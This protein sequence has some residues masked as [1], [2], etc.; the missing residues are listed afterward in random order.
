VFFAPQ[1]RQSLSLSSPLDL[2]FR[3]WQYTREGDARSG[4]GWPHPRMAW[5]GAGPR[6]MVMW[7]PCCS[8]RSPL[9]A[10]FVFW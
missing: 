6:H 2:G 3:G 10:T 7:A 5:P 4:P 1:R 9:L 8:F